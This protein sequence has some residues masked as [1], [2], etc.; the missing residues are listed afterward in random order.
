MER[1][2]GAASASV[3]EYNVRFPRSIMHPQYKNFTH[4]EAEK[5][6]TEVSSMVHTVLSSV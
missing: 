5:H 6:L 1:I 3:R 4:V 2:R